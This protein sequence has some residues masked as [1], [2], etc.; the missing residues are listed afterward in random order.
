VLAFRYDWRETRWLEIIDDGTDL[1][2]NIGSD[3]G[4]RLGANIMSQPRATHL[5]GAP[6]LIGVC[7]FSLNTDPAQAV[8]YH[9]SEF[10]P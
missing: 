1:S 6:D 4:S 5:G 10:V 3:L 7:G 2:V 9:L 8:I